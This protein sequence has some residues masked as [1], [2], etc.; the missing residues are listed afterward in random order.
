MLGCATAKCATHSRKFPS[1]DL[2]VSK[3]LS[4]AVPF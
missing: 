2:H 4:V 1:V 3:K